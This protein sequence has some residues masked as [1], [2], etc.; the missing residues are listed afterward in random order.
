NKSKPIGNKSKLPLPPGPKPWP[1]VGNLPE[2]L[3]N[4]PYPPWIHNLMDEMNTEIACIR[5]GNVHVITV[6]SPELGREFLKNQDAIF[7]I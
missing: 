4:K 3:S 2:M 1:I 7:L 5:L 6:T